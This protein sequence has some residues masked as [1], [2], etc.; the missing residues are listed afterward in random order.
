MLERYAPA[1]SGRSSEIRWKASTHDVACRSGSSSMNFVWP[2]TIRWVRERPGGRGGTVSTDHIRPLGSSSRDVI[3]NL[4]SG[5]VALIRPDSPISAGRSSWFS[6]TMNARPSFVRINVRSFFRPSNFLA[7]FP[8]V[9]VLPPCVDEWTTVLPI[10]MIRSLPL[11]FSVF[12]H[13]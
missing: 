2:Y 13:L 11:R 1:G 8:G 7:N 12:A 3:L 4:S 6:E 10:L 9:E 5:M